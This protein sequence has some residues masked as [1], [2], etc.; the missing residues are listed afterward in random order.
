[1][2]VAGTVQHFAEFVQS[3]NRDTATVE[4]LRITLEEK[5]ST[6]REPWQQR[7]FSNCVFDYLFI[8]TET[9]I[10]RRLSGE[11]DSLLGVNREKGVKV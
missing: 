2:N 11:L 8:G 3:L 6:L 1:V 4:E 9:Q 10:K 7:A 5:M